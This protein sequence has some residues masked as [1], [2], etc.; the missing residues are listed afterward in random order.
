MITT[1]PQPVVKRTESLPGL[2]GGHGIS[3]TPQ[4]LE[5]GVQHTL[6]DDV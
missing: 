1:L 3:A 6:R 5:R 4:W 2:A